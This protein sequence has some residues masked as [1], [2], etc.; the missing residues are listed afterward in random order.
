[1]DKL[2]YNYHTHTYRCGHASGT[3]ED[4]VKRAIQCGIKRMGF[5]DHFPLR[6]S[7]GTESSFRLPV[8]EVP[9]YSEEVFRLREKYK[10]DIEIF[11]GFETEYYFELKDEMLASA[12]EYG[13]EYLILGQHIYAP[14]NKGG[15]HSFAAQ[16]EE[17]L[18][19]YV[20]SI[21]EA[22]K[23][24][25]YTYVC[26]PDMINFV[27]DLDYYREQSARLIKASNEYGVPLEINLYGMRDG[28]HY[29]NEEF[30]RVAGR[31]GAR[32]TL[33][34]DS[35]H[36]KHVADQ[37]EIIRGLRLADKFGIE[38]LDEVKLIDPRF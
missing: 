26:H 38:V 18:T 3:E 5:S 31:L 4:Y 9:L 33:G 25:K 13:A 29:P 21:I 14:E 12:K 35:H 2:L 15:C 17:G 1:M 37:N 23:T 28:R 6:F 11:L 22:I 34:F 20:D 19:K 32:A 36:E 7:D 24:G 27:G 8:N 10:N 16:S 30:W